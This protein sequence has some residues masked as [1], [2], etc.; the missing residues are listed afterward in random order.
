MRTDE[1]RAAED[2]ENR[3]NEAVKA[4]RL[5][6]GP[7]CAW[8]L[9]H[10]AYMIGSGRGSIRLT[11]ADRTLLLKA[12]EFAKASALADLPATISREDI[13]RG[14]AALVDQI[15]F[16]S[17]TPTQRVEWGDEKA[18][19]SA[20]ARIFRNQLH[21]IDLELGIA[22]RAEARRA[23]VIANLRQLGVDIVLPEIKRRGAA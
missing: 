1:E 14:V 20:R 21:N 22:K 7:D 6:T 17:Q 18:D 12:L 13:L 15:E 16:W 23:L 2:Y 19:M 9:G 10:A 4:F 8:Y 3:V 5:A 11:D